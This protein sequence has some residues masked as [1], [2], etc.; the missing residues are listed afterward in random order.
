MSGVVKAVWPEKRIDEL[1]GALVG[2]TAI[3]SDNGH[4]RCL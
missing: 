1:A 4:K 2:D 3:S